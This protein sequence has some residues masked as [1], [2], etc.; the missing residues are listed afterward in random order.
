[1]SDLPSD[2][3]TPGEPPFSYT[4]V[5]LF[6]PFN[7]KRCRSVLKRYGCVFTCLRIRAVHIEVVQTLD[8]DSF[9]NALQRFIC[10][11]GQP[12]EFRSDNGTNFVGAEKELNG[13]LQQKSIEWRFNSPTASH[14][15]GV[16]ERQIRSIR[17]VLSVLMKEQ[18]VD[19]ENLSTLF[20]LVESIIYICI[21]NLVEIG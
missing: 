18:S 11:R 12:K 20:C 19:D 6:G 14:M 5:D 10:R 15:G 7:V 9:I 8:T 13:F 16:W 3:I 17:R 2:R 21:P 4:G 1:M